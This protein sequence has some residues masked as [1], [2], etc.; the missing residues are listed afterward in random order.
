[1]R[2]LAAGPVDQLHLM[3]FPFL[4]DGTP[5]SSFELADT[6]QAGETVFLVYRKKAG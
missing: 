2:L 6:Q 3:V 1:L 4:A 5:S